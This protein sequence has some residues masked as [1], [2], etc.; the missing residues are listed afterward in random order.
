MRIATL[1]AFS[2]AFNP[3]SFQ[4]PLRGVRREGL[5]PLLWTLMCSRPRSTRVC[6][7]VVS[8][9]DLTWLS[10]FLG[11]CR[12]RRGLYTLLTNVHSLNTPYLRLSISRCLLY[13]LFNAIFHATCV[14]PMQVMRV[15]LTRGADVFC[16]FAAAAIQ[17]LLVP[18]R[19]DGF[20]RFVWPVC[21]L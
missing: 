10:C 2:S 11:S 4:L 20:G 5:W 13:I 8:V 15:S 9:E 6:F 19:K 14:G 17:L 21:L 16:M 1:Y 7:V 18:M 12:C 3:V